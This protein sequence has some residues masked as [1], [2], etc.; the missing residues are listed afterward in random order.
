[1]GILLGLGDTELLETCVADDFAQ[2]HLDIL[3][4]EEDVQTLELGIV[5]SHAAIVERD[6]LHTLLW[7]ILLGKHRSNL[8][9]AVVAIVEED[10]GVARLD[11]THSLAVAC[12]YAWL[13]ELIGHT[14]IIRSL[15]TFYRIGILTAH[16][17]GKLV[18]SLLDAV[19]TLVAVHSI[20]TSGDGS[21]FATTYL[22]AVIL[23]GLDE[24]DT[25]VWVGVTTIH[26]AVEE[27]PAFEAICLGKVNKFQ[28]VSEARMYAAGRSETHEV[29][30]ATLLGIFEGA[31]NFRILGDGAIFA[32]HIDLHKVLIYDTTAADVHV[33][34][35]RVTHL[36][37][38]QAHVETVGAEL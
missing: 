20:E 17:S 24:T 34:H 7:H 26:E 25:R 13:N 31:Y 8:L 35:F 1:M 5:R 28:K 3:L 11:G 18:V 21:D 6:G 30:A 15:H 36:S 19:P 22:V 10:D 2:R 4:R 37:S 12:Q 14:I 16:T 38:R 9:G 33:T 23:D 29:D 27:S 32:G